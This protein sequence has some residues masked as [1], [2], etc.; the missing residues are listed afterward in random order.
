MI[1][2]STFVLNLKEQQIKEL[3]NTLKATSEDTKNVSLQL[4]AGKN[5]YSERVSERLVDS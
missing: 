4:V 2:L 5:G 1:L 3:E